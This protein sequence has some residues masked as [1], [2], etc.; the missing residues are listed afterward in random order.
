MVSKGNSFLPLLVSLGYFVNSFA[1]VSDILLPPGLFQSGRKGR[2]WLNGQK[3]LL[4]NG[5]SSSQVT[6]VKF[7]MQW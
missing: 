7:W 5:L 3:H 2:G 4:L 1:K 6:K